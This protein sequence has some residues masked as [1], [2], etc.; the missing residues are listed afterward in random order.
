MKKTL[1]IIIGLLVLAGIVF[2]I[3][4]P[5]RIKTGKLDGF[6]QCIKDKGVLFYGAFWCPHCQS[7]KALFGNSVHLLP[8]IECSNPDGQSQTQACTNAGIKIYPTW[9]FPPG[10][11]SSAP[12]ST[13]TQRV[14]GE[15]ELTDLAQKTGCVLP[16]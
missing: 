13:T 16:Q 6:A 3:V 5:G 7:Q 4:S 14:V 15:L 1:Y 8:Y 2:L 12:V 11:S 9:D 10:L